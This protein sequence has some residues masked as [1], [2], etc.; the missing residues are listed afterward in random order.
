MLF[1]R[2]AEQRVVQDPKW[3]DWAKGSD[4]LMAS[5][6][7]GVNVNQDTA[8]RALAVYGS[9]S[10][11]CNTI[12]TL[13]VDV[14]RDK[15]DQ[16]VE[17]AAPGWLVRPNVEWDL[18]SWI[19]EFVRCLLLDGNAYVVP[20][21][22][23]VGTVVEAWLIP[24]RLVHVTRHRP[25]EPKTY[26]INGDVWTGEIRHVTGPWRDPSGLKGLS[27]IDA[28]AT[29]IGIALASAEHGAR[30]FGQGVALSGVIETPGELSTESAKVIR[31]TFGRDHGG[32]AKAHLPGVL[33]GGAT[34]KS[35]SM[36]AEQAQFLETRKY[37]ASEIAGQLFH[38][39]PTELGIPLD[40]TSLTY[41]N[42]ESRGVRLA[43]TT[44]LPWI[45]RVEQV[46]TEFLPRPQYAR[47][48]IDAL[49]RADLAA[50]YTSYGQALNGAQPWLTVDEVRELENLPPMPAGAEPP[51]PPEDPAMSVQESQT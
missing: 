42:L 15:D 30:L 33:T 25:A 46:F 4:I 8:A 26:I 22:N 10:L 41:Q 2:L 40:G 29:S 13:P 5:T 48:N 31:N 3:Q 38:V 19:S 37:S 27:P 9:V 32:L 21:R 51:S 45:R 47:L 34:W 18:M 1:R 20:V 16:P 14:Y 39:D 6:P 7:A 28:A 49:L 11:I 35:V 12:S 43:R 50:R 23:Q 44:C 17:V 24:P 36:T